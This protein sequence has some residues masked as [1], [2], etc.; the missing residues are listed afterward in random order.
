MFSALCR[1][2]LYAVAV[3]LFW[4]TCPAQEPVSGLL[5]DSLTRGA[6]M[7]KRLDE[8]DIDIESPRKAR[9][10]HRY[11]YTILKPLGDQYS[12]VS[13]WYDKFHD[14]G[15]ITATLYD[16]TGK[17]VKKVKKSDLEDWNIDG[18]G[19]LMM[20]IRLKRYRFGYHLYPYT[21]AVEEETDL[22]GLFSLPPQWTPQPSMVVSIVKSSMVIHLP[23][24]YALQYHSYHL[25]APV[26]S[27]G[28]K[29][30]LTWTVTNCPAANEQYANVFER[31]KGRVDLAPGSFDMEGHKGSA[32]SWQDFGRFVGGLF[33]GRDVLPPEA[34]QLV[35]SLTDSLSDPREKINVLYDFLQHNTHYVGIELGM[36]GWQPFDASYVYKQRYGDCKALANY[37]VALLKEAGIRAFP[38]LIRAGVGMHTIDTDIACNQFNHVIAAAFSGSDTVWL[39][40]TSQTLPPGYLGGFTADRDGLL[41]DE[42]GGHIVHTP[43]YGI[44]ENWLTRTIKGRVDDDGNLEA[45]VD[46]RMSG[47]SQDLTQ[48]FVDRQPKK[49]LI[50]MMRRSIDLPDV[51]IRDLQFQSKR[52]DVPVLQERCGMSAGRF[53]LFTGKRMM[54]GPG[55]LITRRVH[56]IIF[57]ST[58]IDSF[59]VERS[60]EITDS[61]QLELPRGWVPEGNLPNFAASGHFG[62]YIIHS[63]FAD[64]MLILVIRTREFKGVY[65]PEDYAR[66]VRAGDLVYREMNR[67]YYFVRVTTP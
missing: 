24:D 38:V 26:I 37:M 46:N 48:S 11:V 63:R 60:Y 18:M 33:Q 39:E 65:P 34:K 12:V 21:I 16:S 25:P 19:M 67:P 45:T 8:T 61:I 3:C 66:K 58:K 64:G 50:D 5:P 17:V 23:P 43:V 52:A 20:D 53:A 55:S 14:L 47:L 2:G 42:A 4:H 36:G 57:S 13:A 62:D 32:E 6:A 1:I 10:H 22:N 29:K 35:H 54:I 28:K 15:S 31:H 51:I 49:D 44:G 27:E 41:L 30:T 40:C 9:V 56:P 7:V 59:E